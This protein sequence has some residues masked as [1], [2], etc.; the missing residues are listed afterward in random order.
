M[1]WKQTKQMMQPTIILTSN[2]LFN[3]MQE[4]SH[5]IQIKIAQLKHLGTNLFE[6]IIYKIN[7]I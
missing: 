4:L 7:Q 3:L 6:T 5:Y 2:Q 1:K